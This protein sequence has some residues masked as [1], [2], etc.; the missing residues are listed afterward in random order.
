MEIPIFHWGLEFILSVL[1]L[2]PGKTNFWI[3]QLLLYL[4]PI[5]ISPFQLRQVLLCDNREQMFDGVRDMAVIIL[6]VTKF[7]VM[8]YNKSNLHS[9]LID[10]EDDWKNTKDAEEMKI[11]MKYTKY[12]HKFCVYGW[13]LYTITT[14]A[15]FGQFLIL[16]LTSENKILL[17]PVAYPFDIN[18][19]P[20][21][22]AAQIYQT[23]TFGCWNCANSLSEIL[24]GTLIF[25]FSGRLEILQ[26][27]IDSLNIPL[28]SMN[29]NQDIITIIKSV[30]NHHRKLLRMNKKI[31]SIYCYICLAQFFKSTVT[32]CLAGYLIIT[33]M[34]AVDFVLIAKYIL[35]ISLILVQS[36]AI[37]YS[38]EMLL[39][40]SSE[41]PQSICDCAWYQTSPEKV[42]LLLFIIMRTQQPMSLSV[43][44]FTELSIKSFT[45]ILQTSFSYLSVLR[46]AYT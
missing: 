24:L 1:G 42:K 25:H 12:A 41:I 10:L 22:I 29:N 17:I 37:C 33:T 31:E 32:L 14:I 40:K 30:V 2:W 26:N 34:D 36:F 27:E 9:L 43:G 18:S 16:N 39:T 19:L 3:P 44:K 7:V 5:V 6:L 11:M 8:R 20:V 15:Y 21:F 45:K 35:F 23:F 46:T 38:G 4:S 28:N 13:S